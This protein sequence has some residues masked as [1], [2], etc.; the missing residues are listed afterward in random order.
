MRLRISPLD[1]WII[2]SMTSLDGGVNG[3]DEVDACWESV[4]CMAFRMSV[5][6]MGLKLNVH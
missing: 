5:G 1:V 2:S 6:A 4:D 3:A